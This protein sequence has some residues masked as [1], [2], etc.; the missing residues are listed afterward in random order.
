MRI[1]YPTTFDHIKRGKFRAPWSYLH[2]DVEWD[3]GYDIFTCNE[4]MRRAIS[5]SDTD[6]E[7]TCTI[8]CP[9]TYKRRDGVAIWVGDQGR[10]GKPYPFVYVCYTDDTEA[11]EGARKYR[12]RR[13]GIDSGICGDSHY[14]VAWYNTWVR[15]CLRKGVPKE[16]LRDWL[17]D[18]IGREW[19][20]E[21]QYNERT[22]D[23]VFRFS[24][25]YGDQ[26]YRTNTDDIGHAKRMCRAIPYQQLV[27]MGF[28]T[29]MFEINSRGT[30]Q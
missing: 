12:D 22:K 11:I 5:R 24:G 30:L 4:A 28:L 27:D 9:T 16:K 21:L 1:V 14:S 13:N 6:E 29:P 7:F 18:G 10:R 3:N 15:D 26:Y 17:S 20:R 19:F 2:G 25:H 23:I 8:I